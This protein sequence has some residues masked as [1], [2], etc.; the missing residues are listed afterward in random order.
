MKQLICPICND[1]INN[2][3]RAKGIHAKKHNISS[4][5]LYLLL[6]NCEKKLCECGCQQETSWSGWKN[7]YKKFVKGHMSEKSRKSGA[8]KLKKTLSSNHWSRGKTKDSCQTIQKIAEKTSETLKKKY[9]TGELKHWAK[10]E[11]TLTHKSLKNRSMKMS[12]K[13]SSDSH[14]NF[15]DIESIREK[16]YDAMK[17]KFQCDLKNLN[18]LKRRENNRDKNYSI[19]IE[20]T[21]CGKI[22]TKT[23]YEIVRHRKFGLKCARCDRNESSIA[24]KEI[25]NFVRSII[26]DSV[27]ENDRSNATGF[28]LD[29]WI[30]SRSVA[31]EY[32][33][34]YWHC[35]A[36]NDKKSYHNDKI[37]QAKRNS[38]KLM[39]IFEDEWRDK[40]NI[41]ESMI[42]IRLGIVDKKIGARQCSIESITNEEAKNFLNEN[43]LDG[44]VKSSSAFALKFNDEIVSCITLRRPFSKKWKG[45]TEIARF[46]SKKNVIVHGAFSKFLKHLVKEDSKILTYVD[47]R[48]G[49]SGNH[50]RAMKYSGKSRS[51][52]WTD[53]H[54]RF[55]RLYC[56]ATRNLTER[57]VSI[58][59]GVFKIYGCDILL[60]Q[61][62]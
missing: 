25:A 56:R 38:I 14:W 29:I 55:N 33:G 35:D 1:V 16:I 52:F 36:I 2:T 19:E 41:V 62:E 37:V 54:K 59:K 26:N 32:N 40:R 46:A 50:C 9:R 24:Q 28:E 4:E 44:H 39:H 12:K 7:G 51:F 17:D 60:F 48:W 57:Q 34:L 15:D 58:E 6:E 53:K 11:T 31:F 22:H 18:D 27:F 30:P 5:Q 20:C 3:S 61:Y 43:H 21:R 45:W 8:M 47:T 13:M 23:V 42:K 49:S 10:G